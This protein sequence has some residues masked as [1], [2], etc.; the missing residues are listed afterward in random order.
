MKDFKT[1]Y[2]SLVTGD[3]PNSVG[4]NASGASASDGTPF[5]ADLI[6]DLWGWQK[7]IMY[8]AGM[9]PSGVADDY[10]ASDIV[11]ALSRVI[12]GP[13][14]FAQVALNA[15]ELALRRLLPLTGQQLL[16][17]SYPNLCAAVYV[18]D[19]ANPTAGAF[20]KCTS[21]GTRSTSGTYLKMPDA[22]GVF[23][24]GL[25]TNVTLKM[26][27]GTGYSGGTYPG[28]SLLDVMMGH[29]HDS[30]NGAS[31]GGS[32][33]GTTYPSST[34]TRAQVTQS[35]TIV[36]GATSDNVHGDPRLGFENAPASIAAQICIT[37]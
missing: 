17:S 24:R 5:C 27:S 16:I 34:F 1:I 8:L 33:G 20:Y 2:G 31:S 15:T 36:I 22:R 12:R 19:A 21:D 9:T 14:E 30:Y 7:R 13:G 4:K 29:W 23:L 35:G 37:Y 26:A 3:W 32:F 6:N 28:D 11:T 18:G 10:S 25:G